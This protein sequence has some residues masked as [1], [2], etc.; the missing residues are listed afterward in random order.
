VTSS[1]RDK[2]RDVL[3][4]SSSAGDEAYWDER[5][6]VAINKVK[7]EILKAPDWPENEI[8][9]GILGIGTGLSA[10][11]ILANPDDPE[12][13]IAIAE[14]AEEF[15]PLMYAA[16]RQLKSSW[17]DE[18]KQQITDL[19]AKVATLSQQVS[20]LQQRLSELDA[21][22]QEVI[23]LRGRRDILPLTLAIIA[24]VLGV[25]AVRLSVARRQRA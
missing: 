9:A 7:S 8:V 22:E 1:I 24:L 19:D 11:D 14:E 25:A 10:E 12:I 4:T 20:A 16:L 5:L 15:Q 18:L 13:V 23:N 3:D 17:V 21:L 6:S 2:I